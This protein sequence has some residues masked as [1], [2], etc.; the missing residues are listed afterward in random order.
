MVL[1]LVCELSG[2]NYPTIGASGGVFGLFLAY[3]MRYSNQMLILLFPPMP[4]K[5]KWFIT[6]YAVFELWAGLTGSAAE[7]AHF[8]HLGGMLFGFLLILYWRRHHP[9][10]G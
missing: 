7:V 5:E 2:D 4:I 10:Q 3:G 9:H 6:L 8:A 1:S